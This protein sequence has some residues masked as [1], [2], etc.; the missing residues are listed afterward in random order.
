MLQSITGGL[1]YTLRALSVGGDLV[2]DPVATVYEVRNPLTTLCDVGNC[3]ALLDTAPCVG[4]NT[5]RAS[6]IP[7]HD[8]RDVESESTHHFVGVNT[9]TG[10]GMHTRPVGSSLKSRHRVLS[11]VE[12]RQSGP[13]EDEIPFCGGSCIPPDCISTPLGAHMRSPLA[14]PETPMVDF[15]NGVQT[16]HPSETPR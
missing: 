9:M 2:G 1:C 11:P 6:D 7:T 15:P 16:Y 14:S 12:G 4:I 8:V 10:S 5:N 3:R 13:L